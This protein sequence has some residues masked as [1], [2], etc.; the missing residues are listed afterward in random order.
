MIK[1]FEEEKLE[2]AKKREERKQL[3]MQQKQTDDKQTGSALGTKTSSTAPISKPMKPKLSKIEQR[4]LEFERQQQ[5][6]NLEIDRMQ[7]AVEDDLS[8]KAEIFNHKLKFA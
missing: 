2:Q 8:M 1:K 3:K 7:M 6:A 5:E 4:K